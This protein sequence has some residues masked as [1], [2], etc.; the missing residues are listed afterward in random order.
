MG[1]LGGNIA[2]TEIIITNRDPSP[3]SCEV[4]MLFHQGTSGGPE[5]SFNEPFGQL[6]GHNLLRTSLSRGGAQ[7]FTL[8]PTDAEQLIVGAVWVFV[9]SPCSVDS[10]QVQG[11][12]L[13][14]NRIDGEIE[15]IFSVS[16]QGPQE[17]LGD[18][19][20]QVLTGIFG[21]GRDV[22]F[23]SVTSN[24]EKGAP[25]GT[26][27]HF[28]SFD[29]EGNLIG[30]PPSGEISGAQS[31]FFPWSFEE[32][33]IIEMCLDVPEPV[34]GSLA[35]GTTDSNFY[36]STLAVGVM[37]TEISQQWTDEIFVDV[38]P[39]GSPSAWSDPGP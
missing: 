29:L 18:G 7:I 3:Q 27:L 35:D 34:S 24:P 25:P 17:W 5:V 16:G 15:E 28:R 12:Y 11:R 6:V 23:A 36:I 21:T 2:Q 39:A 1:P 31:A 33:T 14:R 8:T 4:A 32:P 9:Q 13:L 10:L 20:C 37:Q 22:G 26:W 38:F 19:D 30:N